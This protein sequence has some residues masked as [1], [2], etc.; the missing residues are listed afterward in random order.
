MQYSIR[1][2]SARAARTHQI[3]V[4][5]TWTWLLSLAGG[6][7]EGAN[8][9]VRVPTIAAA[10]SAMVA[11]KAADSTALKGVLSEQGGADS[12]ADAIMRVGL[13]N[14]SRSPVTTW[15]ATAE[16]TID[17]EVFDHAGSPVAL[18]A[19]GK[20][21]RTAKM[22]DL[23][24]R[25]SVELLPGESYEYV[26]PIARRFDMSVPGDYTIVAVICIPSPDLPQP[27]LRSDPLHI[28]ITADSDWMGERI[29]DQR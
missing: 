15:V 8:P 19:Y 22:L 11:S 18:T 27:L 17:F 29:K 3:T 5:L 28:V 21:V 2:S 26:V 1:H 25:Y 14:I 16:Q 24:H 23:N 4:L 9:H 13:L 7:G 10:P 20:R 12:G 6:C